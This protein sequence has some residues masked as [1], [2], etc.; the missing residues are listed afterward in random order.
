MHHRKFD[1]DTDTIAA[2]ILRELRELDGNLI[3]REIIMHTH[4]NLKEGMG[5]CD[6]L[7]VG[8]KE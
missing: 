2:D 3:W 7:V 4:S 1:W 8:R 6:K 5:D